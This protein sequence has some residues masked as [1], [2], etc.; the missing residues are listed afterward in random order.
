M[1]DKSLGYGLLVIGILIM[2]FGMIQIALLVTTVIK[3]YPTF[4]FT[5]IFKNTNTPQVQELLNKVQGTSGAEAAAQS[6][7]ISA[8]NPDVAN[9]V[10]N[11]A[12]YFFFMSFIAT[13][14]YRISTL[15]VKMIRPAVLKMTPTDVQNSFPSGGNIINQPSPVAV[16]EMANQAKT[17]FQ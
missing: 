10:L 7:A 3:P 9:V 8:L 12:V 1:P 16:Q 6:A 13:I 11:F 2:I 4:R 17:T 15:G 5:E 14:G